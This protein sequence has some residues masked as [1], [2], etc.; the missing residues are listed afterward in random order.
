MH[1]SSHNG[2]SPIKPFPLLRQP[3]FRLLA[4][5][6]AIGVSVAVLMIAGLVALNPFR[7]R[8]L[9]LADQSPATALGVLLFGFVI[10]FG[11]TAMGTAI[12]TL[13]APREGGGRRTPTPPGAPARVHLRAGK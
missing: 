3:L 9:I 7:L 10:T 11:S 13:A 4:I 8:D 1:I 5:N 12:M 2:V 6:L